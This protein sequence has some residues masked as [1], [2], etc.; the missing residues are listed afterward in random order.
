MIKGFYRLACLVLVLATSTFEWL[1][2]QDFE[3]YLEDYAELLGQEDLNHLYDELL[4]IWENP[5]DLNHC[6]EEDIHALPMLT[7]YEK[8]ALVEYLLRYRPLDALSELLMVRGWTPYSLQKVRDFVCLTDMEAKKPKDKQTWKSG[9]WQVKQKLNFRMGA[10]LADCDYVGSMASHAYQLSYQQRDWQFGFCLDKDE[11]ERWG[12]H[13]GGY[14]EIKDLPYV[15]QVVVGDYRIHFGQGLTVSSGLFGGKSQAA[16]SLLSQTQSFRPQRSCAESGYFRGAAAVVDFS[17]KASLAFCIDWQKIDTNLEDSVFR[18]IKTDG[19]HREDK[20]LAKKD[21]V[22]RLCLGLR[23]Q[24]RHEQFQWALNAFYYHFDHAWH[25]EWQAYNHYY[26]RGK[27][28]ANFSADWRWR[29]GNVFWGGECAFDHLGHWAA[30]CH[31]NIKPHSDIALFL[32]L[33]RFQAAYQAPFAATFSEKSQVCNEEAVFLSGH[34]VLLKN[35]VVSCYVD[36]YRFPWLRYGVNAPSL[37][38]DSQLDIDWQASASVRVTWRYKEK[39][40]E[41]NVLA[42]ASP[43]G[44]RPIQGQ[45]TRSGR[46]QIV[47]SLDKLR[48]KTSLQGASC[49]EKKA[50]CL[51]QEIRYQVDDG[52]F[53]LSLQQALFDGDQGLS[54]YL[55]SNDLAGSMPFVNLSGKGQFT[56]VMMKYR[57]SQHCQWQVRAKLQAQRDKAALT[58]IGMLLT[59]KF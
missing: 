58:S 47:M 42:E 53:S 8:E 2:A 18:S 36:A 46:A 1:Y 51:S 59:F 40:Q 7:L 21:N 35:C 12:D 32:S 37:G 48:L 15:R 55:Y 44:V 43:V 24:F 11:G 19:L 33:R 38:W 17:E 30:I 9:K 31:L 41:K 54:S 4:A 25:A 34:F 50:Y 22:Q 5:I 3:A 45:V 16:T 26:F 27:S 57:C 14:L 28:A 10:E 29:I 49:A 20:D 56:S 52:P 39:R 23:Q 13:G 6:S